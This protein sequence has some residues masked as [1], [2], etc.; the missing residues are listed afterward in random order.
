MNK[1]DNELSYRDYG[2]ANNDYSS[3]EN[4]K[5]LINRSFGSKHKRA[6]SSLLKLK[7]LKANRVSLERF[8]EQKNAPRDNKIDRL[9]KCK[10]F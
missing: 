4:H 9:N 2:H 7:K 1:Y 8:I 3:S 5:L 10:Y 6:D